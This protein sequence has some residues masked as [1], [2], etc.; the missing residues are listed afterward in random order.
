[1]N[2]SPFNTVAAAYDADFTE[3]ALG[4]WLRTAVWERLEAAFQPGNWVLELGCGTGEDAIHLAQ[5]GVAVHATDSAAAMLEVARHK[6]VLQGVGDRV[7]FD[8]FDVNRLD[9]NQPPTPPH[10]HTPKQPYDGAFS[11]F[12]ALNAV[13]DL[14]V[15]AEALGRWIRPGGRLVLVVMGPWCP[16]EWGWYL[17]RGQ[18]RTAFRRFRSGD[19]AHVGE[20]ARMRV[21][22][23]SPQ[24]MRR[25]MA[26]YF[27]LVETTGLGV[28]L[29]PTFARNLVDRWPDFFERLAG[30]DRKVGRVFP[31]TWL[32][33]HYLTCFERTGVEVHD[34]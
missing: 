22:Y 2:P 8:Q 23:P 15:L 11:N 14:S 31:G 21:W 3:H 19:L 29:P 33:D 28:L 16:W 6:A 26:P 32:N 27:H 17:A 34:A 18:V 20:G 25:T 10:S 13:P 5:R 30:L 4:R 12:G 9:P 24:R 1:M 7:T